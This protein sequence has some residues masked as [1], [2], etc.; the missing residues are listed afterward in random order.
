M[1]KPVA[2]ITLGIDMDFADVG[3]VRVVQGQEIN[4]PGAGERQAQLGVEGRV[5]VLGPEEGFAR[6]GGDPVA[7]LGV[8]AER[9]G[10]VGDGSAGRRWIHEGRLDAQPGRHA[11][12]KG[13]DAVD[14]GA[15][16]ARAAGAFSPGAL[17][18]RAHVP[19]VSED[20]AVDAASGEADGSDVELTRHGPIGP[21]LDTNGDCRRPFKRR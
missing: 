14:P 9:V 6:R 11:V 7:D 20:P 16:A 10:I 8:R 12:R 3:L 13:R 15:A 19:R 21:I 2:Q 4:R 1:A 18:I 5:G 17:A